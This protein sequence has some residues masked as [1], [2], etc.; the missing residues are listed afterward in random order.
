MKFVI[1]S[2]VFSEKIGGVIVL[3][4]LAYKL[5][6]QGHIA[7]I[8]QKPK[9]SAHELKNARGWVKLVKW[10]KLLAGNVVKR[11]RSSPPHGLPLARNRDLDDAII[12]YPEI[13]DG[14][15]LGAQRVVRWFLQKPGSHTG[16]LNFGSRDLFF[17]YNKHFND[18][19]LNPHPDR[20]LRVTHLKSDVYRK[21]NHGIRTG[22]C[23]I[24]KKGKNRLLDYHDEGA[25][26]VDGLSHEEIS[27]I[28]NKCEYFVSYDLYTMYS[29][30]A[31]MCGC[32][33]VVVPQEGLIK[34]D[35]R[36]EVEIRYGIAYGWQD[37]SWARQTRSSLLTYLAEK[38]DRET[39][40]VRNFVRI[41]RQYFQ[42]TSH[43]TDVSR[44]TR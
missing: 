27:Y 32:I 33:P 13:T 7:L 8:W 41:T 15:P 42:S 37:I 30:Y 20:H 28:F 14:N 44:V 22:Q 2:P 39:E 10:M 29:R 21:I 17:Y 3:H 25:I 4:E 6:E 18:W 26:K 24:V 9:P 43:R 35:W 31:A 11:R 23:Y 38:E 16:N 1:W 12:I 19:D 36:P 34:E 5:R 40:S